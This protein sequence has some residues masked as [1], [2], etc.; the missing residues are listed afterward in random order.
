MSY[1]LIPNTIIIFVTYILYIIYYLA[2][3]NI[4]YRHGLNKIEQRILTVVTKIPNTS[5]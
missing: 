4:I 3:T 1:T 2:N 5:K